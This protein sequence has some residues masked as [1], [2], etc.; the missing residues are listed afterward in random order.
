MSALEIATDLYRTTMDCDCKERDKIL[1]GRSRRESSVH[2]IM[3]VCK[4]NI[5]FTKLN[6]NYSQF[7]SINNKLKRHAG[8]QSSNIKQSTID[9]V[10]Y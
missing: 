5:T 8:L 1:N 7:I 6:T 4:I 2:L 10:R 9:E 3:V